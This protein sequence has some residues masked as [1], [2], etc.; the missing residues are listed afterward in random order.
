N[1]QDTS[2][3]GAILRFEV[4]DNGCGIGREQ[5]ALIFDAFS[6]ADNSM[7]RTHGGTGLGLAISRQLC[8]LMGGTIG[9]ES[10]PGRGATFWFTV[11][12]KEP[13]SKPLKT[14]THLLDL[15]GLRVLVV[16]DCVQTR[17]IFQDFI[18]SWKGLVEVAPN[19]TVGLDKLRAA[20]KNGR[21]FAVAVLDWRMPGMDGVSMARII[22]GDNQL[23]HTG[24]VLMSSF[25]QIADS[26][27][28]KEGGFAAC[29]PKP[30]SRS[31]LYDAI[32]TAANGDLRT[33]REPLRKQMAQPS[34]STDVASE[35]I[36][37]AEDNEIN[38]EVATEFIAEL[39]YRCKWARTGR[40]A[41][42]AIRAGKVDLVLMDCQMPEMDGYEAARIIRRW[43]TENADKPGGQRIPI[44][45]LTAHA[46]KSDRDRCLEAGMDDYLT[47]PLDPEELAKTLQKWLK[48]TGR[49]CRQET[50]LA[51]R[52]KA[53]DEQWVII[54]YPS[55]LERCMGKRDLAERLVQMFLKNTQDNLQELESAVQKNDAASTAEIAHSIKGAAGSVSAMTMWEVSAQ[56]EAMGRE[57]NLVE[58]PA[59]VGQLREHLQLLRA[60]LE[61][62]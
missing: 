14:S 43:E 35:T 52:G 51:D 1:R 6:Q 8:E 41:V 42:E 11:R 60:G 53:G 34:A 39:G 19:A 22:K 16:E 33:L 30:I 50:E 38:R 62:S 20:A 15:K 2:H 9:V 37:L 17:E 10:D 61:T 44:V 57:K 59:L 48:G 40:E 7:S 31:D 26:D 47:K 23:K 54:D 32:L 28:V 55:L 13:G 24:L 3:E 45:A 4:R 25:A 49:S 36:L 12:L 56:L 58:A 46:A 29:V 27:D 5:Q 18:L 21:P